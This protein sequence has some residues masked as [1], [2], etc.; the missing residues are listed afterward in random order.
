MFVVDRDPLRRGQIQ[1]IEFSNSQVP[2]LWESPAL[3]ELK[4][5]DPILFGLLRIRILPVR[6]ESE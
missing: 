5:R 1:C 3:G 6:I 4:N 2:D